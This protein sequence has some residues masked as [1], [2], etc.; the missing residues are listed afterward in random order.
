MKQNNWLKYEVE[1]MLLPTAYE[2]HPWLVVSGSSELDGFRI[3][4]GC[5]DIVTVDNA[6][7]EWNLGQ[8][9]GQSE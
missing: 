2:N 9:G 5:S 1:E 7:F 4:R 8:G 3:F 6:V